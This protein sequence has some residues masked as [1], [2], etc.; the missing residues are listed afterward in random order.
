VR[1]TLLDIR[2]VCRKNKMH[3]SPLQRDHGLL[4]LAIHAPGSMQ[5]DKNQ[6]E[7]QTDCGKP[8]AYPQDRMC[9]TTGFSASRFFVQ[10]R[11]SADTMLVQPLRERVNR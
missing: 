9:R 10:H 8:P 5:N 3:P 11:F 4:A 7:N 6:P 1:Q 2:L